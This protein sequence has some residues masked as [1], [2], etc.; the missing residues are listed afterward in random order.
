MF[1]QGEIQTSASR[2]AI[3]VP[4]NAVYRDDTSVKVSYV[5]VVADGKARR[6]QVRIGREL[7][8]QLEIVE[9]LASGELLVPERSMELADG[10]PVKL[11]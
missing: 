5:Y 7:G 2:Q 9:G 4:L 11:N 10:V 3:L 6:R 1:V 8:Q